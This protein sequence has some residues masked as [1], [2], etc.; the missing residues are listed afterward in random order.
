MICAVLLNAL[1][2]YIGLALLRVIGK[3]LIALF[4]IINAI[5]IYFI[6]T[7]AVI[8][9]RTMIG[10]VLNT[11]YEE[12]SSFFSFSL[13]VN[14]ILLGVLPSYFIFKFSINYDSVK[15]SFIQIFLTLFILQ[16][17]AYVNS[18]NWLWIDKNSKTL[19]ALIMPWSYL[20]NTVRFFNHKNKK[21]V[22]QILLPDATIKDTE[23]SVVILVIGEFARSS[24]FSLYGYEKETNPLLSKISNVNHFIAESCATYTTAGLKCI[25]EHKNS[26][27]LY[28]I[29]PN[30][31]HRNGVDVIWKTTNWGEPE[32]TIPKFKNKQDLRE[33]CEGDSCNYDEI[34]L[35]NLK[36]DIT[37][38]T[39]DKILIVLHTST[40]HGPSYYKKY[41][42]VFEKFKPVCKSVELGDCTQQELI[43][44]YDNTIVYTDYIL[45]SIIE[46]LSSLNGYNASMIYISDHGESLGVKKFVY[47]RYS[48]Q[49]GT[50]RA[51]GYSIYHLEIS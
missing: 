43:N 29:L 14:I 32:V 25:L 28:E 12:S 50:Q 40:S 41:P 7:Y 35:A 37:S 24:N 8:I 27:E 13:V 20:V 31:L 26:S 42:K 23:K 5:A 18:P 33:Q 38:S 3:W 30:Y 1:V 19:G 39:R 2:F 15:R 48:S 34:L 49:Y 11:N 4:F 36:I 45:T 47:A 16:S 6:N 21:N 9:D 17:I 10:N 44:A 46:N 51:I 22:K